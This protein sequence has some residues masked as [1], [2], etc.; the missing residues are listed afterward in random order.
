MRCR[1]STETKCFASNGKLEESVQIRVANA[2]VF[3]VCSTVATTRAHGVHC[4][5]VGT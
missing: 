3:S 4:P 5:I 1:K 2:H